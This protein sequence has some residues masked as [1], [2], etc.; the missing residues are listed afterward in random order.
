MLGVL[1]AAGA[2]T[3][4]RAIGTRANTS[5]TLS[6]FAFCCVVVSSFWMIVKHIS[7]VIPTQPIFVLFLF[8]IGIFG[9]LAQTLLTLGLQKETVG[10]GTL[11]VYIQIL[12]AGVLEQ[13][14][15]HTKISFLSII[16]ITIILGA[17]IFIAMSKQTA[18]KLTQADLG[19]G[20]DEGA[21]LV[22]DD[23]DR[24]V[25]VELGSM[26]NSRELVAP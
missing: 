10:R 6:Y 15:L 12:Y 2:Y 20:E 18:R 26:S 8:L 5:H 25:S 13:A 24:E 22:Y 11:G 19:L 3:S 21:P 16:G 23:V 4:I 9:F 17:A 7:L 14:F 1:G